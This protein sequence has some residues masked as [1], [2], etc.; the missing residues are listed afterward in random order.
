MAPRFAPGRFGSQ[1]TPGYG[2]AVTIPCP[3]CRQPAEQGTDNRWRPFCSERCQLA[4]LS[5]W[6][7]ESYVIAGEQA[8]GD[9]EDGNDPPAE[10]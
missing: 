5:R 9:E 4:D 7:G 8:D 3:N 2:R 10:A 1:G 6:L